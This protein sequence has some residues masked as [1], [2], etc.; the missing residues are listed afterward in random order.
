MDTYPFLFQSNAMPRRRTEPREHAE[1]GEPPQARGGRRE[2][3][4]CTVQEE[5]PQEALLPPH[6]VR[7]PAPADAPDQHAHVDGAGQDLCC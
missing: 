6:L 7:E 5:R 3:A 1:E 2:E 4:R